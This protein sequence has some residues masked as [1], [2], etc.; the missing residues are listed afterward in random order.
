MIERRVPFW[1]VGEEGEV[2]G[3]GARLDGVEGDEA[4]WESWEPFVS[5]AVVAAIKDLIIFKYI[6][7]R[8][9]L[10]FS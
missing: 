1:G 10:K 7:C 4:L 8:S 9:A 6:Y 2:N 5:A 3:A